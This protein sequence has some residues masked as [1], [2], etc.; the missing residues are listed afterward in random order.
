MLPK[1]V[2]TFEIPTAHPRLCVVASPN[3]SH[4]HC[5]PTRQCELVVVQVGFSRTYLCTVPVSYLL[6]HRALQ[7]IEGQQQHVFTHGR[8]H[9][10]T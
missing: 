5:C 9:V 6:F 8:L 7:C 1:P 3:P 10:C 4:A 2:E